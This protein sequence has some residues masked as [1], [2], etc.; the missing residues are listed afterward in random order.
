MKTDAKEVM[1]NLKHSFIK[2]KKLYEEVADELLKL[3]K[4]GELQPGERLPS[5]EQLAETYQVG[6][7][8]I[9]EAL[10]AL[11]AQGL[12]EMRQGEGTFIK[13]FDPRVLTSA[14]N[15]STDLMSQKD[16]E[17]LLE[18]RKILERGSVV[19]AIKHATDQ[20][21]NEIY[22]ALEDM[23]QAK[24]N[25]ELGDKADLRFHMGI[26]KASN[27]QMLIELMNQV[28]EMIGKVMHE[29]RRIWL[30]QQTTL[31]KIYKE[32]RDI[33]EAILNRDT[34]KAQM[35]MHLHLTSVEETLLNKHDVKK[36]K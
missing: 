24:G 14:F 36:N 4:N 23:R 7:S 10:S 11:R 19:S 18:I 22:Q 2:P 26:A 29:T 16:L 31:E 17:D 25:E 33:Y 35:L 9:R 27:N 28:S 3:I 13:N 5:V 12:L 15:T 32:H 21:L 6:R 1:I 30:S 34:D 8:A 20:D